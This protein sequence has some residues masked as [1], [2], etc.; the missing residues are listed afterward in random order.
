MR[1]QTI[2]YKV[3]RKTSDYNKYIKWFVEKYAEDGKLIGSS[4]YRTEKEARQTIKPNSQIF[5]GN[6]EVCT[7]YQEIK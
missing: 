6:E 1:Y 5:I 4:G 3:I 2:K 7:I